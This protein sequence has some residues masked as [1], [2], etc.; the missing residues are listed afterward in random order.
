MTNLNHDNLIKELSILGK[1]ARLSIT[2]RQKIRDQLFKKMGQVNLIDAVTTQTEVGDLVMPLSTLQRLFR[3]KSISFGIPATAG[4]VLAIFVVTFATGAFAQSAKPGDPL[5]GVRKALETVQ[6]ALTTDPAN[7]ATLKMNIVNDRIKALENA[8]SSNLSIALN[9]SKKALASA[10]ASISTLGSDKEL[11]TKLKTVIESQKTTLSA[12]AKGTVSNEDAKK[13]ILAMRDQLDKLI[14]P[15]TDKPA[16]TKTT[17][18]AV[19]A[20]KPEIIDDAN[21]TSFYGSLT[22]SYG[23]P[24]LFENGKAYVLAGVSIDLMQYIGSQSVSI[25]GHLNGKIL[26]VTK[27][28]INSKLI[29]ENTPDKDDNNLSWVEGDQN[30]SLR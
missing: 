3:P 15:V 21:R 18:T 19:V 28:T 20:V 23:S 11:T 24:A 13:T 29:W 5:F 30:S 8:D 7:R 4:M 26:T 9:E 2:Q 17:D 16:D 27:I 10:Q 22:T 6:I 14:T 25:V 1:D 12:I